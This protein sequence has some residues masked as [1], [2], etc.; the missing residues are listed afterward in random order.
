MQ[1]PSHLQPAFLFGSLVLHHQGQHSCVLTTYL[2]Y[3]VFLHTDLFMSVEMN[4]LLGL[5]EWLIDSR[6]IWFSA[7]VLH[8]GL[9]ISVL[10]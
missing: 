2:F 8:I 10:K 4:S 7:P 1:K 3:T 9:F 5:T 6:F